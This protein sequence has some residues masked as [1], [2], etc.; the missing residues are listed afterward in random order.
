MSRI[1]STKIISLQEK[2]LNV[3]AGEAVIIEIAAV[4]AMII[5]DAAFGLSAYAAW[6][7]TVKGT[8][9]FWWSCVVYAVL[10]V[11]AE[12]VIAAVS[13]LYVYFFHAIA[14]DKSSVTNVVG[15]TSLRIVCI[16]SHIAALIGIALFFY[17]DN[18][19]DTFADAP[20][21][22]FTTEDGLVSVSHILGFF[23]LNALTTVLFTLM[24]VQFY[25]ASNDATVH[26]AARS[27]KAYIRTTET[28]AA[29]KKD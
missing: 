2:L 22:P 10:I 20:L 17:T 16:V 18:L 5:L 25:F 11:V 28:P 21:P 26:S 29:G 3:M 4:F 24:N 13:S 8:E 1:K 6:Y 14:Y 7:E 15:V 19:R 23:V 9:I 27:M 12:T